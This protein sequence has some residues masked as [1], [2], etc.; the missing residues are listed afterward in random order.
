[1][2]RMPTTAAPMPVTPP[3]ERVLAAG[4]RVPSVLDPPA[5]IQRRGAPPAPEN[6]R[7][8]S[9]TPNKCS[10]SPQRSKKPN[11][12]AQ[13]SSDRLTY[14]EIISRNILAARF[15]YPGSGETRALTSDFAST[16]LR[17][18]I[19]KFNSERMVVSPR[20]VGYGGSRY[21]FLTDTEL[22]Q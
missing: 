11:L 19:Y 12:P 2:Y 3:S 15:K 9:R 17:S 13:P 14:T 22:R 1:M 7:S 18:L 10:P 8:E 21:D 6:A 16:K 5:Q 4:P 20:L